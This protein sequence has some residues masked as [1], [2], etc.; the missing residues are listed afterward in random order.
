MNEDAPEGEESVPIPEPPPPPPGDVIPFMPDADLDLRPQIPD[1]YD[2]LK[3]EG[4]LM[5][6]FA[7]K[8]MPYREYLLTNHWRTVRLRALRD[9]DYR[10]FLCFKR[11]RLDVHHVDEQYRCR[12]EETPADVV[13][14]C[15][16]PDGCHKYKHEV[17]AQRARAEAARQFNRP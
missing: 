10:C 4:R 17:F 13:A 8:G 7:L 2:H 12:G 15:S 9:A 1:D 3:D 11:V 6:T 16:G 5:I 14:L